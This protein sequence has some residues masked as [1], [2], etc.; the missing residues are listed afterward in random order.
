MKIRKN[1]GAHGNETKIDRNVSGFK[2]VVYFCYCNA[3]G[4]TAMWLKLLPVQGQFN[5]LFFFVSNLKEC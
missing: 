5:A 4:N 3:K 1:T 2:F